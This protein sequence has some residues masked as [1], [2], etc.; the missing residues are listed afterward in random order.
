MIK[1]FR[2]IRQQLLTENKLS[3]YLL[4]AIGEIC[5]VAIG[6]LIALQ[7]SNWNEIDKKNRQ[8]KTY[9]QSLISEL[10]ADLKTLKTM[11][12]YSTRWIESINNYVLYYN[13][14]NKDINVLIQKMDS[15]K[16]HKSSYESIAYTIDDIISTGNLS[17]FSR[18]KKN[19][20]LSLK[21]IT[22]RNIFYRTKIDG[23]LVLKEVEFDSAV[24]LLFLRNQ[25]TIE[26][27]NVKNWKRNLKSEQ[28]RLFNNKMSEAL[29][30][31]KKQININKNIIKATENLLKTLQ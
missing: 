17:L 10:K 4:Y 6:I 20:I 15:I 9:E 12:T 29:T 24:D 2:K 28:Y 25:S 8:R 18:D 7:V 14:T 1:F 3:K 30:A 13:N 16:T 19:A 26:H 27:D 11:N 31:H 5:L 23:K 22:E 21:N